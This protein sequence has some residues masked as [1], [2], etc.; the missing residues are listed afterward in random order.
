MDGL[1]ADSE[2]SA[3][4]KLESL[5]W[6]LTADGSWK[7]PQGWIHTERQAL[8]HLE[9]YSTMTRPIRPEE[10]PDGERLAYAFGMLDAALL[11]ED[12][13]A[14]EYGL[15]PYARSVLRLLA[16]HLRRRVDEIDARAAALTPE[17]PNEKWETH[18][19]G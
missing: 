11:A 14:T 1:F 5:G 6:S 9:G 15:H 4:A 18:R 17:R 8:R 2:R 10:L 13:G 19:D 16:K 12:T 3:R 7:D